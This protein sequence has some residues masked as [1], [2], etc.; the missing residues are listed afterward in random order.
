MSVPAH[1]PFDYVALEQLKREIKANPDAYRVK[2]SDVSQL[3]PISVIDLPG[4]G[5]S[6]AVDI[7]KKMKIND[8]NSPD[9]E[10]DQEYT[11]GL[12]RQQNEGNTGQYVGLNVQAAK[13]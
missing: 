5:E 3:E 12:P 7:V 9:L 10:G 4:F 1:A 8:Q 2:P 11:A 13:R 6:P